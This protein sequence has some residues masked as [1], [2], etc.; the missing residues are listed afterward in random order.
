MTGPDYA[1]SIRASHEWYG[2]ND[3]GADGF[4]SCRSDTKTVAADHPPAG[5]PSR[6]SRWSPR[7]SEEAYRF[8]AGPLRTPGRAYNQTGARQTPLRLVPQ[9]NDSS[10]YG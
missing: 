3:R 8:S 4:Q 2:L 7:P 9:E 5:A 1:G 6:K 10:R